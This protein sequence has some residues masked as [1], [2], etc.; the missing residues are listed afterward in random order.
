M[1]LAVHVAM[2]YY[3]ART[4]ISSRPIWWKKYLT[5]LQ[6]IQFVI[7][8]TIIF[9]ATTTL[10]LNRYFPSFNVPSCRGTEFSVSPSIPLF[11]LFSHFLSTSKWKVSFN[12][13]YGKIGFRWM[14]FNF[15]VPTFVHSI[16]SQNVHVPISKKS[17]DSKA[18]QSTITS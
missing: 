10:C 14:P 1:N 5:T 7:D 15:N 4:A 13:T 11:L 12:F 3:Y 9:F 8:I 2:Y 6:I 18:K 16:L 17:G